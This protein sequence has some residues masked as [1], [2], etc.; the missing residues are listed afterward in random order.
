V[1]QH[2]RQAQLADWRQVPAV[3]TA[4]APSPAN[5]GYAGGALSQVRATWTAPDGARRAGEVLADPGSRAGS[6]VLLWVNSAGTPTGPPLLGHQ[7]GEQAVLAAVVA[8]ALLGM[9]LVCAGWVARRVLDGRRMAAWDAEWRVN[10][11]RW[12]PHR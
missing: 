5:T 9:V 4:T 1:A 12:S 8:A 6:K 7:V 10:G 2:T 11:P 3:L